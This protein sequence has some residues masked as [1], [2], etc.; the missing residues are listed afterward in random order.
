VAKSKVVVVVC[1]LLNPR[2]YV[3]RP[4]E[5]CTA[6]GFYVV[7]NCSH[8]NN[9]KVFL[10]YLASAKWFLIYLKS[11]FA[12]R[13]SFVSPRTNFAEDRYQ[14]RKHPRHLADCRLLE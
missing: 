9:F 1:E 4:H 11:L 5:T 6:V 14:H 13:I 12:L 7:V 8:H 3:A 10:S 2:E